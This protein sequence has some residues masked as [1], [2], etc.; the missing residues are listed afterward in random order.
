MKSMKSRKKTR[1][2]KMR[3]GEREDIASWKIKMKKN[4][5]V[6]RLKCTEGVL[7]N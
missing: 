3:V 4:Q 2:R 6:K 7:S 5:W 1:R